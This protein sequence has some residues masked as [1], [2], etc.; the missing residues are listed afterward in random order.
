MKRLIGLTALATSA[1]IGASLAN[2]GEG[3]A[4]EGRNAVAFDMA[5]CECRD[6]A[7]DD[8]QSR[9]FTRCMAH[10]GWTRAQV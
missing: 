9:A 6:I 2:P 3:L 10:R 7:G 4:W 5:T 1:M 8:P